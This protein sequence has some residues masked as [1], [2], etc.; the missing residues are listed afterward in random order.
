MN[1][2]HKNIG[3]LT[4]TKNLG[5]YNLGSLVAIFTGWGNNYANLV[6]RKA[7]YIS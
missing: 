4:A 1:L 2:N 7:L 5:P 3:S 6:S